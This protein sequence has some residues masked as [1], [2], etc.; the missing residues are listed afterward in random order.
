MRL[1]NAASGHAAVQA[2]YGISLPS[3]ANNGDFSLWQGARWLAQQWG[4]VA[5]EA[6]SYDELYHMLDGVI[7]ADRFLLLSPTS[8]L[9]VRVDQ[10]AA[11]Y[12]PSDLVVLNPQMATDLALTNNAEWSCYLTANGEIAARVRWWRDG[13]PQ[14]VDI[15]HSWGEGAALTL[16]E[17][18]KKE[19]EAKT[20]PLHINSIAWRTVQSEISGGMTKSAKAFSSKLLS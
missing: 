2:A 11:S 1:L 3:L 18:G 14:S 13:S 4:V 17:Q 6:K 19:L 8:D 15:E 7:W 10:G 20:G 9:V 12:V 16:T 5:N